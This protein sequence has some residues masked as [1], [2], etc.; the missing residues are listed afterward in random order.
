MKKF[1]SVVLVV[2]MC[3]SLCACGKSDAVK[4]VEAQIEALSAESTYK[5]L[6]AV[7]E[8]YDALEAEE[9][10]KVENIDILAKYINPQ[11]GGF[12]LTEDMIEELEEYFGSRD[13][14][15]SIQRML[16][17][18]IKF[19]IYSSLPYA[20]DWESAG[21]YVCKVYDVKDDY[22]FTQYGKVDIK[23]KNGSI[24]THDFEINCSMV[25]DE[26]NDSYKMDEAVKVFS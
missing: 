2:V 9:K 11:N 21:E 20:S 7:F 8:L 4:N 1:L 12:V 14:V 6:N 19:A 22:T 26:E 16:N 5:E 24:T 23:N 18:E 25:Y 17:T 13:N 10:E 15:Y 3:L